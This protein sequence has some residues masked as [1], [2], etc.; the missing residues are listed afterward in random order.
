MANCVQCDVPIREGEHF[1]GACG[2]RQLPVVKASES[3]ADLPS[4]DSDQET[5]ENV[6][7]ADI[8]PNG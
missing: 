6:K 3:V 2:T 8:R 4:G 7:K 5:L 1:C